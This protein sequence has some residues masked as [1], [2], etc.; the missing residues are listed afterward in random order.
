MKNYN[1]NDTVEMML[2][3]DYKERFK[4]EYLQTCI[5]YIKLSKFLC[6]LRDER[7]DFYP[8]CD[9]GIL[10]CQLDIMAAYLTILNKRAQIEGI[11][12]KEDV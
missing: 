3:D 10:E 2:S 6:D 8:I 4:A 12:F 9:I 11:N 5:R 1:L 7:I